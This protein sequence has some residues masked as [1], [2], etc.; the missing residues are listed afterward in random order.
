MIA[1]GIR[2]SCERHGILACVSWSTAN[3]IRAR[4]VAYAY[5][6]D[7]ERLCDLHE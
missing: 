2:R 1:E 3:V 5:G 7:S 4:L 6:L